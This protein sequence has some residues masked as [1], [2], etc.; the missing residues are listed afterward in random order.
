VS[1]RGVRERRAADRMGR[2]AEWLA[3]WRLRLAGWRILARRAR[4]PLGEIDLVARR[5]RVVAFVEVKARPTLEEAQFA[6]GERQFRR[7]GE[8]AEMWLARR[9]P[10]LAMDRRFDAILVVPRR[11]PRHLADVWRPDA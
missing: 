7:I 1:R 8:A 4:T 9:P 2:R 5:G 6:L 10:L 3:V 11:W